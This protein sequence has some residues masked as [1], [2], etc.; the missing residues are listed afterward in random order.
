MFKVKNTKFLLP[1][2]FESNQSTL[3]DPCI[4]AAYAA[5]F[6]SDYESNEDRLITTFY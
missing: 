6:R 5:N 2:Y 1:G 3:E 4:L